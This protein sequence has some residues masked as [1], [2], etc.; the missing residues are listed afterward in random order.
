[1][2]ATLYLLDTDHMTVWERGG[3]EKVRL[4]ERLDSI[5]PDDYGTTIINFEEQMRGWLAEIAGTAQKPDVQTQQY[6]RL[7]ELLRYYQFF[8]VWQYDERSAAIYQVLVKQ[9]VRVGTQDLKI[10]S[11]ALANDATVLTRNT[12]DFGKVPGLKVEDWTI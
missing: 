6:Q 1:M 8:S 7:G 11:I 12:R 10:A 4:K 9:K 3:L 5:A 2:P